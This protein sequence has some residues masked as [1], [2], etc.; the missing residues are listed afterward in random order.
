M[1]EDDH[2]DNSRWKAFV[3]EHAKNFN[4]PVL[5]EM[6]KDIREIEAGMKEIREWQKEG[7]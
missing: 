2:I 4:T 1:N 6:M 7:K 5:D 3:Y